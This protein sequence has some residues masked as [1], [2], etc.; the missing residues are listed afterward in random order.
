MRTTSCT[1]DTDAND[2]A[3]KAQQEFQRP[4]YYSP[5]HILA[6]FYTSHSTAPS[7][8]LIRYVA[9]IVDLAIDLHQI[10]RA[11]PLRH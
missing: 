6:P 9:S 3:V 5:P 4:R 1:L 11:P 7:N 2:R 10:E 8:W